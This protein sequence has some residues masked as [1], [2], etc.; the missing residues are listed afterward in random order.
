[1][2]TETEQTSTTDKV[3]EQDTMDETASEETAAAE[4]DPLAELQAERD[5]LRDQVVRATADFENYRRRARK[6]TEDAKN[7]GKEDALREL[8]P[9]FDNLERAVSASD[10]TADLASVVEGVRMVLKLFEDTAQRM[11][12]ERVPGVGERFD[13]SMHEAIQQMETDEKEPGTIMA[14]VAP[15][16]RIEGRLLR[17]GMV[18][19]ARAKAKES[20][21]EAEGNAD[22]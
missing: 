2:S 9:V 16:Y 20:A 18:V 21:S 14:E 10:G 6:E 8:L 17:A 3:E 5:K 11:G 12:L 13:P 4:A 22:A 1:V 7:R 19:V 15:G